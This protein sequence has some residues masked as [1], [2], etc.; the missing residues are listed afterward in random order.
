MPQSRQ[1]IG[2]AN[3]RSSTPPPPRMIWWVSASALRWVLLP[4]LLVSMFAYSVMKIDRAERFCEIVGSL[5]TQVEQ[6]R[7]NGE[8]GIADPHSTSEFE[9][10]E[11][12]NHQVHVRDRSG[13]SFWLPESQVQIVFERSPKIGIRIG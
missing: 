2:S 5:A 13:Q 8:D 4:L 3:D 9:V 6:V 1:L 11:A 7:A 12:A 10:I